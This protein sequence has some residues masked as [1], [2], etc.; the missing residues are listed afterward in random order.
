ML[1]VNTMDLNNFSEPGV[2]KI[3]KKNEKTPFKEMYP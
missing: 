1:K 2:L 3:L